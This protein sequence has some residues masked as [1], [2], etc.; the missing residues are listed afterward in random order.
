MVDLLWNNDINSNFSEVKGRQTLNCVFCSLI[1]SLT[2]KF[3]LILVLY[4]NFMIISVSVTNAEDNKFYFS[5]AASETS[6]IYESL[7]HLTE[8]PVPPQRQSR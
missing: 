6:G 8:D 5:G 2:S 7:E 3:N 1:L 4:F